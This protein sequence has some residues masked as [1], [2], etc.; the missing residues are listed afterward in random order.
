VRPASAP[1]ANLSPPPRAAAPIVPQRPP[2][3]P[4]APGPSLLRRVIVPAGCI[5]LA[6]IVTA[7]DL[8]LRISGPG[9]MF[10]SVRAFWVA[11]VLFLIGAGLF[12]WRL[13]GDQGD[14]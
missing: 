13:L 11:G 2:P 7:T 12:F 5:V 8:I 6:T 3:P 1:G 14:G 10:G 9:L 4:P